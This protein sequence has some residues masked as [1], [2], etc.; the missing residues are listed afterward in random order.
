M[1]KNLA[2]DSDKGNYTLKNLL[3]S[4]AV[5][6]FFVSIIFYYYRMIYVEKRS[7]I[8]KDGQMSAIKTSDQVGDYL[9]ASI[10]AVELTSYTMEK[11][12]V[13]G[14]SADDILNYI[15]GQT[16][17]VQSTV[18]ENTTGI[19]AYTKNGD[20]LDGAGWVPDP[21]YDPTTRPWYIKAREND[22]NVTLIDPYLDAQTG[23]IMMSIA[24]MLSD[25]ISVVSMDINL[26]RIQLITEEAVK[27]GNSDYVVILD[28]DDIVVAHSNKEDAGKDYSKV[29]DGFWAKV[30]ELV[31]NSEDE[32][33]E[34][35]YNN[36][37][38][39]IYNMVLD[40][41]WKC[42]TISN[43]TSTFKPLIV[44][45]VTT[46]AIVL[47]IVII[48]TYIMYN[49]SRR[50][51][52]ADKL[53]KQLSSIANT[54]YSLFDI[55]V[56]RNSYSLIKS[57]DQLESEEAERPIANAKEALKEA[58][59]S[60]SSE[61]SKNDVLDFIDFN[62]LNERLRKQDT[63]ALEFLS[64][65]NVWCRLRF[66]VSK[67][68]PD[69]TINHVL[70]IVEGID[71]EKRR[72]DQLIEMSEKAFA[73]S[74]A[75]SDFLS[76]MSH[77]I[78]TPINAVLGMNEMILRESKEENI[79]GYSE[80]IKNSG[81]T[82][83][84]LI[85]DI[86]DFS[87]IESGKIEIVPVNYDLSVSVN[88]LAS[89]I[90]ARADAK[91][92]QFVLEINEKTPKKLYGDEVRI[93]QVITNILTNAVKYTEKGSIT[94]SVDYE[95]VK[96]EPD[97][98]MLNVSVKDTGIGI[99]KEDIDKLFVEYERIEEKRNRHIEGTGL[100]MSIT[101]SLLELMGSTIQ[102]DSVYGIGSK[103]SFSIKQKFVSS[104]TVGD[105]KVSYEKVS[106]DRKKYKAKFVA[107]DAE[108]LVIDDNMMNIAVF[109]RL[110][111]QTELKIDSAESGDEGLALTKDK[112]YDIIFIDHMMPKKSGIETLEELKQDDDNPNQESVTI[113]L[114]ANAI[115]GVR[116]KYI[117]AG[118]DDYLSKPIDTNKL[119][120]MLIE[121][122][123][124]EKVKMN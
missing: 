47:V 35:E 32:Y 91:G 87:K 52:M 55:D 95:N 34:L 59:I 96:G 122:L 9:S 2:K 93:K 28:S 26:G 92:L 23:T 123:P 18:F 40:S 68:N 19:Y 25:G 110:L 84:N 12:L 80:D 17:S 49:S 73:E 105:N 61:I 7:S 113:C 29:E 41:G 14:E 33:A 44:I 121:Y 13:D 124:D 88:E 38:Y 65:N 63:I 118:F 67:R 3:I 4:I 31:Y 114:T 97:A 119:E 98:I 46:I 78:R 115:A 106:K 54:F 104:E 53:N 75:K 51:Y 45:L 86:L 6:I 103:F 58:S 108:L 85:N 111:K 117:E 70:W 79:L 116:D 22:G 37:H 66:V 50:L 81:N 36:E 24:K 69:G 11:M 94:F 101:K 76:N 107:P 83:L 102:V 60:M 64:N 56:M 42:L 16:T 8:I 71:E 27:S 89:M 100:G 30:M 48:L 20:Y 39:I 57:I 82:L 15:V 5:I 21:G 72:R 120:N 99:K 74:K 62:R 1:G 43:S 10:E 77:E 90:K 112:K 109:K